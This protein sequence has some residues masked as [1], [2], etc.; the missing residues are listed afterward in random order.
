MNQTEANS[1]NHKTIEWFSQKL[2]SNVRQS[3]LERAK[4]KLI[5][6]KAMSKVAIAFNHQND[7]M[8]LA[9]N[10]FWVKMSNR[11]LH[12]WVNLANYD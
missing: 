7:M 11:W 12:T 3:S 4:K 6:L 2:L 8:I 1:A 10:V 5:K 9:S